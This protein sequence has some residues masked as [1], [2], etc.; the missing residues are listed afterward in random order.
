MDLTCCKQVK[1]FNKF[2]LCKFHKTAVYKFARSLFVCLFNKQEFI[3][4]CPVWILCLNS[5]RDSVCK[6]WWKV[7][8]YFQIRDRNFFFVSPAQNVCA[9]FFVLCIVG[10]I[11]KIFS[12]F[13][14]K[15]SIFFEEFQLISYLTNRC[16]KG[17]SQGQQFHF[18][19]SRIL[20]CSFVRRVFTFHIISIL[21]Y[22]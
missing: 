13:G 20:W 11:T 9:T 1:R 10:T 12:V 18:G 16:H 14:N 5:T 4:L 7:R 21:K 19:V 6:V 15:A 22:R 2:V 8:L 3:C 17:H